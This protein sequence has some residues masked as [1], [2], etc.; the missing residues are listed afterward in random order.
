[1]KISIEESQNQYFVGIRRKISSFS[2]QKKK[3]FYCYEMQCLMITYENL[4]K[5][6]GYGDVDFIKES[7][8][9]CWNICKE[10]IDISVK[11]NFL[12]KL[13]RN[14]PNV[15]KNYGTGKF[16]TSAIYLIQII[17]MFFKEEYSNVFELV[18][19]YLEGVDYIFVFDKLESEDKDT[20]WVLE[21]YIKEREF[22][23][24]VISIIENDTAGDI[25]QFRDY[26]D[27]GSLFIA[28]CKD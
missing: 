11:K 20:Y 4:H 16:F 26:I 27:R 12:K 18:D 15:D 14:T 17:K 21:N 23:S 24:S 5:E 1:M 3:L 28:F 7:L 10:D 13:A 6:T 9:T 8:D 2:E 22:V 25:E 19:C